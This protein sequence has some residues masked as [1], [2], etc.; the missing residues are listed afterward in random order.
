[1]QVYTGEG[2]GK[3]TAALGLSI[4]AVGAGLKVFFAQFIKGKFSS[5]LAALERYAD[6]ITVK[7]YGRGCFIRGK[8]E[9]PDIAAAGE[10]LR[11][12]RKVLQSGEYDLV[13]LDEGCVA[14]HLG[15]FSPADLLDVIDAADD[16]VEIVITG[17]NAPQRILDR[18]DLVTEMTEIKHYHQQGV[19]PRKGIE[20]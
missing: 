16:K 19:R 18:A 7:Q 13:V 3:T 20:E 17:R 9:E 5:E 8:P 12:I 11:D 15:L 1:M 14:A 4:R 10:G 2:K 6:Q